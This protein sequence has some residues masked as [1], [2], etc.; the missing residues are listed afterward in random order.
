MVYN[1]LTIFTAQKIKELLLQTLMDIKAYIDSGILE[2]YCLELFDTGLGNE[3]GGLRTAHPEVAQELDEIE[4]TIEKLAQ[5]QAIAP[6]PRLKN[7]ILR[8]L[9]F[10]PEPIDLDNLPAADAYADHEAWLKA[11]EHLV[12]AQPFD[13]FFSQLLQ[14]NERLA[15]TLVVTKIDV[16]EEV[17]DVI[18]ESFFILKGT[19]TCTV[20]DKKI[21][22]NA[23]DY[24][25]I[26]LHT[27]HDIH[28]ESSYVIAILQHIFPE[29]EPGI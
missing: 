17:H 22:L 28:I 29:P 13:D 14:Q 6:K 27:T 19:C 23:G 10:A 18:A 9:N 16:P 21:T 3:V 2:Q 11:V 24:L 1:R 26:P 5:S 8:A 7:K 12:P 25:N 15:Q 4:L 20:G